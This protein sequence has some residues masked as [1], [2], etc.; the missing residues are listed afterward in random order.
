MRPQSKF[1]KPRSIESEF[2]WFDEDEL[3]ET[4]IADEIAVE[5]I[6][7]ACR[8]VIEQ[9]GTIVQISFGT[10]LERRLV[11]IET[12]FFYALAEN[13]RCCPLGAL[14]IGERA[15]GSPLATAM[16]RLKVDQMW[17]VGFIHGVDRLTVMTLGAR[18]Y[19]LERNA[20]YVAG[21]AAGMKVGR[22]FIQVGSF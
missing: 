18:K 12:E 16:R 6:R 15:W 5:E 9:G 10:A 17:V 19:L 8:R 3:L 13:K 7:A 1:K 2:D 22:E 20:N 11:G 14:L 21:V 4:N